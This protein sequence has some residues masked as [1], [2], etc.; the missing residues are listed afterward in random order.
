MEVGF[1]R[2]VFRMDDLLAVIIDCLLTGYVVKVIN[3]GK[4][5]EEMSVVQSVYFRGT[6]EDIGPCTDLC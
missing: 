5:P 6:R 1:L 3:E 2:K 4:C